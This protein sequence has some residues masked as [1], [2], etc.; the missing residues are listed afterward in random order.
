MRQQSPSPGHPSTADEAWYWLKRVLHSGSLCITSY[1]PILREMWFVDCSCKSIVNFA[2]KKMGL[3]FVCKFFVGKTLCY[4][5]SVS[6]VVA[7][8]W[9]NSAVAE[10]VAVHHC[11]LYKPKKELFPMFTLLSYVERSNRQ[12][13]G[14]VCLIHP[15]IY[16]V[17]QPH[18]WHRAR[19]ISC[20]SNG[21]CSTAFTETVVKN[22]WQF[23]MEVLTWHTARRNS[24]FYW[25]L[26]NDR[27]EHWWCSH[28]SCLPGW[29][30]LSPI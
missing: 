21:P 14:Q 27:E 15:F 12:H 10:N 3:L 25:M 6:Q 20:N 22:Q 2:S 18:L 8:C 17:V 1:R 11:C 24:L 26:H 23:R 7:P 16:V 9:D 28:C 5:M 29:S 13:T 4:C 30:T 19:L